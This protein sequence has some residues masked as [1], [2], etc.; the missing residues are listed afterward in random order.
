[1]A[2]SPHGLHISPNGVGIEMKLLLLLA[3]ASVDPSLV[4]RA[5][6]LN[7]EYTQCL[8]ETA[9]SSREQG[10]SSGDL[11]SRLATSCNAERQQLRRVTIQIL[12]LRGFA[13]DQAE[14]Q[15]SRI[16]AQGRASIVR[17]YNF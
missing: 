15:W 10:L 16:E 3:A 5:D 1:M 9:R 13:P 14:A 7:L 12:M 4:E 6:Q 17:A 11:P 2:W 8:F